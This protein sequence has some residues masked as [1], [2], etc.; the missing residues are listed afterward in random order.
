MGFPK[1]RGPSFRL[2]KFEG[3]SSVGVCKGVLYSGK[4]PY[5][6]VQDFLHPG[7]IS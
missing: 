7:E 1:T 6:V 3:F 4:L 5:E 2:H